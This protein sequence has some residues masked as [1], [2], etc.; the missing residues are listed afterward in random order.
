MTPRSSLLVDVALNEPLGTRIHDVGTG[1]GAIALAVKHQRPDLEI[2]G[3]DICPNA[4]HVAQANARRLALHIDFFVSD[5]VPPG[6]FDLV[7]ANLPYLTR[8]QRH[9]LHPELEIEPDLATVVTGDDPLEIIRTVV[10]RAPQGTRIALQH[11]LDLAPEVAL[12][13][14]DG[15]LLFPGQR[16]SVTLGC[17]YAGRT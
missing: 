2:S 7:V 13:L 9:A 10:A 3:S 15:R 6:A 14:R 5:G 16:P 12:L 17:A 4:V 1:C 8:A 11:P